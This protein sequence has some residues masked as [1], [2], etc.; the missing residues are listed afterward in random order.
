MNTRVQVSR[1]N[2]AVILCLVL[3]ESPSHLPEQPLRFLILPVAP[4]PLQLLG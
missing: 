1:L 3:L 4:R 2:H